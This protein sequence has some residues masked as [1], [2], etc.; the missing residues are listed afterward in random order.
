MWKPRQKQKKEH[1][2]SKS[3]NQ[4]K[5]QIAQNRQKIN[6]FWE[7]SDFHNFDHIVIIHG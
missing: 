7:F 5:P 4:A 2:F 3:K 1:S 6:I